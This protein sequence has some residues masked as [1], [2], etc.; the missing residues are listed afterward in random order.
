N[1]GEID[2]PALAED[3]RTAVRFLDDTIDANVY[4]LPAIEAMHKGNRKIG[5]GVMGWADLLI[6]LGLPYNHPES[7]ALARRVMRFIAE[8]SRQASARL[9]VK[10]GV[11]PNFTGSIYDSPGM[12]L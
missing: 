11:F 9:A 4:P 7:F 5:L 12:P 6:L 3:V 1:E 10:R 8:Q 2:Y